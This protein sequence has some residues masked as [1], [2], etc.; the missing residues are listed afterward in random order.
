M[1]NQPIEEKIAERGFIE[2]YASAINAKVIKL[3]KDKDDGGT[4]GIIEINGKERNIEARRKGYPNHRGWSSDK[5]QKGWESPCLSSGIILNERTIRN[6]QG[7][8]FDYLVDIKGFQPR[9]ATITPSM[10][11][12]LLNRP[13]RRMK[14][15]NSGVWQDAKEVPLSWFQEF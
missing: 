4:D 13:T 7:K 6:H 10:V 8:G 5:F 14:S 12:E 11:D 3:Q 15:T 2:N 9:V 1:W